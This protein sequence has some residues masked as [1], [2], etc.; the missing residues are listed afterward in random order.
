MST[1]THLKRYNHFQVCSENI[2]LCDSYYKYIWRVKEHLK[3]TNTS[4]IFQPSSKVCK[5]KILTLC[6]HSS[7]YFLSCNQ[8]HLNK[9]E[10]IETEK[11]LHIE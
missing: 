9:T 10:A 6:Y 4:L 1:T 11:E 5:V 3:H 8:C 7:L 2:I